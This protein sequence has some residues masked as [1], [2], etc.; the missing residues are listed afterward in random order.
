MA[1]IQVLSPGL[2]TTVQDLGRPGHG[3]EGVSPSGAA[4]PISLYVGNRIVR[5][6]ANAS[7]L[8]LTLMGGEYAFPEGAIAAIT[9]SE[10]AATLDGHPVPNWAAIEIG[11]GQTLKLAHTTTGA[12]CYL[13]IRGGIDVPKLYGSASTHLLSGLGG[14]EGR[15]LRKG[16]VLEIGLSVYDHL[17]RAKPSVLAKLIAP[18]ALLA[19]SSVTLRVTAGPQAER[20]SGAPADAFY[21]GAY[22]VTE[23]ANR[24]GIRLEGNAVEDPLKGRM[25]TE[26]VALGAI[27]I[28]AGG[29]PII[30]NVEQQTAGGYPKIANVI[31]AD[32]AVLGQ[33]RPRDRVRFVLV[34]IEEAITALREQQQLLQSEDWIEV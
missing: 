16:D 18:R 12:R 33:V 19:D 28:P 15:A 34:S 27:Q 23:E 13:A 7:G 17:H 25:I 11:G 29:Q 24:T 5:N 2:Q 22:V 8:E 10:F 30:L 9:G 32:L 26:G 31:S 4:D 14:F 1:I 6:P 3:A 20:F 21:G